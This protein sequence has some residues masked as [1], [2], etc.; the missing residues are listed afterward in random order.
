MD[1][2]LWMRL[3]IT[4]TGSK[5]EIESVINGDAQTLTSLLQAGKYKC[6]GDTYIPSDS[7]YSYNADNNTEFDETEVE[8]EIDTQTAANDT[9]V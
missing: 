1:K 6:E 3:G 2:N 5:D 9:I 4:L 8:F 7:I